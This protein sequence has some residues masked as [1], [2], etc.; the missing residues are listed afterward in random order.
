MSRRNAAWLAAAVAV[1]V[2]AAYVLTRR[3]TA[4]PLATSEEVPDEVPVEAPP[5]AAAAP[6]V[7]AVPVAPAPRDTSWSDVPERTVTATEPV[8]SPLPTWARV[9]IVGVAL[10]AFFAVSLIATKGV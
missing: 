5:V 8:E 6:V 9:A 7:P 4:A 3:R 1:L 10:V 2:A